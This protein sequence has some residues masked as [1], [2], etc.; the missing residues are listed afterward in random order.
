MTMSLFG[1]LRTG[2]SGLSAQSSA[3]SIISDNI[4]NVNTIGYKANSA[5]FSTLVTKQVSSTRYSSGGVYCRTRAGVD[6]Q[7]LLS[8]TT[9]S[10]DL[11]I[12]GSGFFVTTQTSQPDVDD[13][14][15]YTRV[16]N[17]SVDQ[18]GYL[19]NDNGFYLQAWPLQAF[20]GE[21]NAS[22]VQIGNNM[23]MKAYTDDAGTT[24]YINDNIIDANNLKAVN[25]NT[26]GGTA[27]ETQNISF[28]ANLPADA[29]VFDPAAPE[30][31]GRYSSAVLVYDSLGN[32]HNA[33]LTFTKTDTGTWSLDVGM[34]SGAATL[35]TYS[36][37]EVT[38]D[39]DQD[40]YSAR[41]QLEF[42]SIPTN[43]SY[44]AM[45]TN[46]K[47][48]V[49]EFTKDGT[50]SYSPAANETVIAV[51]LSAGIVT[52]ADAVEK[53]NDDLNSAAAFA[54]LDSVS[55]QLSL[56]DWQSVEDLFALDLIPEDHTA[57]LRPKIEQ[58][59]HARSAKDWATADA[60]RDE[61]L[62][63]GITILDTPDGPLWQLTK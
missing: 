33:T 60:I 4:A 17:F 51:D 35:V 43:H 1:A 15:S 2:V 20:D 54:Y 27:Q 56:K 37:S 23:Y 29:P 3:M 34:P 50:T 26:I 30:K 41:A 11:G 55:E 32:S 5:S 24:V 39:A 10:T 28:G 7:G 22:L 61:L 52:T 18:D 19:K 63:Q 36:S 58:R 31:G 62:A 42:T 25:L 16:G 53:L 44:V 45:E 47:N 14:W 40:V 21:E 49:F 48:Y 57:T 38:N 46:G 6:I 9:I 12:S 8:S 13:L 59:E